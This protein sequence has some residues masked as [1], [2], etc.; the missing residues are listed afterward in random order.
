MNVS[1]SHSK[2]DWLLDRAQD[3]YSQSGEDGILQAIF[4]FLPNTGARWAVEFGAWDGKK[5][6]NTCHL[7]TSHGWHA[8]LIEANESKFAELRKTYA[9]N[10]KAHCLREFVTFEGASS[11]DA[12]LAR[13]PIPVDFDLLS[14]DIDGADYFVW[15]S[16][17]R[18]RP[19]VVVIEFNPSIPHNIAFTQPRDMAVRQ[20]SS[21]RALTDLAMAKGYELICATAL[22]GIYV[23]REFFSRF[24]IADNSLD[25]LHKDTRCLTQVF[26]LYDGT[27]VWRGCKEL[28]WHGVPI[29]PERMQALPEH[30]RFFMDSDLPEEKRRLVSELSK[31]R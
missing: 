3:F 16:V 18:F 1:G 6:S 15:D 29:K 27:L 17:Q 25:A 5:F 9:G 13:T 31:Y 23:R 21:L 22:N 12:L 14:I 20:G 11:L 30:L 7:V 26:Q 24:G 4:D 10:N 28:L 19:K 2:P 8:V